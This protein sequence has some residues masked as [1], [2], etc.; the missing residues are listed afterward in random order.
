MP[1]VDFSKPEISSVSPRPAAMWPIVRIAEREGVTKQAV[2]KKIPHLLSMGLPVERNARGAVV[3]VDAGEY[4][5][6]V[7]KAFDLTVPSD[8]AAKPGNAPDN[9]AFVALAQLID[10]L[11]T[12]AR[13]IA[14][15]VARHGE[16]GA[17]VLL[18]A[19]AFDL[20]TQ[21]S[22]WRGK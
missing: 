13:E 17:A 2:S 3:G 9:P 16:L 15:A 4:F 8:C 1:Q 5:R 6:L 22:L 7:G 19:L 10:R 12:H 18:K 11:P 14:D 20:H 21:L